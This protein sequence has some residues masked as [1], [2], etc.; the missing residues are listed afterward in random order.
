MAGPSRKVSATV[1]LD[2]EQEYKR[3]LQ[4]LNTGNRTLS[5][6]M[7]K[8]QAEFKGNTEST[9]YLTKAGELLQQQ[10]LQQQDKV[11]KLRE[12]V[13]HAAK[14]YGEGSET[15]QKYIQQLNMAEAAEFNLQHSIEEN[16]KALQGEDKAMAGLGDT[17]SDLAGK[18]GV[19]L[20]QGAT[21]ALNGMSN[22]SKGTVAAM[23]AAVAG[24]MA[25]IKTVKQLQNDALEAAAKADDILARSA[26][27]NISA[28]QYQALQYAAP[29]V[30]VDVDTMA[31]SL[32]KLT[33]AMGDAASGSETAQAKFND[34]GVSITN[35]DGSLRGAY[36]VWLDTMDALAGIANETERDVAAQE[37][38]GKSAAELAPIY[39]EGTEALR[40]YVDAAKDNYA[41]TDD[42]LEALGAVDDA[43]QK[44]QLDI[45][46]NKDVIGAQWA[47][48]AKAALEAFDKLITAAGKALV[49]SGILQAF[50]SLVE[51][52]ISLLEPVT[53]LFK[54]ADD[55]PGKL[56]PVEAALR[57]VAYV[58]ATIQDSIN[59]IRGLLPW[60]WGSGLARTA[61]GWNT[62]QGQLSATGKLYYGDTNSYGTIYDEELGGW[63]GNYGRNATGNDNW[64]GGLTWVG[65]GGPELAFLPRGSYIANA[66]DSRLAGGTNNYYINVTGVEEL[67][68]VISWFQ[69]RQVAA[70]MKG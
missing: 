55:A 4:E 1:V 44:L 14:E 62:S 52:A 18:L 67:E 70:R 38:L 39:R 51:L 36:D 56:A 68:Q 25:L 58:L 15:T 11:N 69:S 27:M 7:K 64:R 16:E 29:F 13:T 45:E 32:Q 42:Q 22:L 2:G 59:V 48:T 5:T 20:P 41:M 57:A 23:G 53:S 46:H 26:Q 19:Q 60:N 37:L 43:W 21:K 6:E 65:E 8:L 66:Q 17:V 30:D 35:T 31:G 40:G 63:I 47:P 3:A 28:Q 12:A 9:E 50:G 49:D 10:L 34:L 33:K 24:V 61:L 54:A